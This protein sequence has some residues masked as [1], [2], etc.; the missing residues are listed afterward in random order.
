MAA[1]DEA[2]QAQYRAYRE[3]Y[4]GEHATQLTKR[5]RRFLQLKYGEEFC[6]NFC[7][8]VVDALAERLTVTGF[9]APDD[10]QLWEWWEAN[11]ADGKQGIV[12]TGG[13][14]DGDFYVLVEWDNDERR[15]VWHPEMAYDG[16]K[17]VRVHY[18]KERRGEITLASKRWKVEDEDLDSAGYKRRINLYYPDRVEKYV[19]DER[20]FEGNW[21]PY[22]EEGEP[23]PLPWTDEEDGEPL[24]VSVIHFK[25]KERGYNWGRSELG[26]VV[27]LQNAQN[28][29]LIDLLAASDLTGFQNYWMLGDD[30]SGIEVTPGSWVYSK[31]PPSEVE[32]G[33][34]EP[35]DPGPLLKVLQELTLKVAQVTRTPISYFQASGHAVAEG[36]LKQQEAG[37]VA[38]A[39]NRQVYFGNA[40]EDVA[41]MSR[42]LNNA[43]GDGGSDPDAP[44]ST[45]WADPQTRN[46]KELA[47]TLGIKREKLQVPIEQIWR[48]AGY[49]PEQIEE[50]KASDEYKARIEMQQAAMQGLGMAQEPGGDEG[51]DDE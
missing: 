25:N 43:F 8:I 23:W 16:R 50:M 34:F 7:P 12:H 51:G 47:E 10:G 41:K 4:D 32:V 38:R 29:V 2:Q 35:G 20:Y 42:R 49:S 21:A 17:G 45:I 1:E 26:D 13:V 33:V 46:E 40:W 31:K 14:R 48:E 3:Y 6:A 5:M 18:S 39:K 24:G 37:L 30:P 15:P 22:Q 9:D 36:T 11:R 19:S 27:P 44:I 28:K